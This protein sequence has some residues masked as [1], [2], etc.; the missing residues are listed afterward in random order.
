MSCL[1]RAASAASAR[2]PRQA[3]ALGDARGDHRRPIA[4]D[5]QAVDRPGSG[6][7]RIAVHRR[8]LVVEPDRNRGVLPRILDQMTAVRREDELHAK[9]SRRLAERAGLIAGRRR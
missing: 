8:V 2:M 6:R 5:E 7:P 1:C 3:E 4:D 9:P